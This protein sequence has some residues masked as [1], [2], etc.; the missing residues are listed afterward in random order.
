[1]TAFDS[2][3]A[4]A[5]QYHRAGQ[6]EEAFKLYRELLAA[7]PADPRVHAQLGLL[8]HQHGAHGQAIEHFEASLRANEAQPG[9]WT[10]RGEAARHLGQLDAAESCFRRALQ[11]KPDCA[12]THN[13]LGLVLAQRGRLREAEASYRQALAFAPGKASTWSNLAN[14]LRDWMRFDEAETALRKAIELDPANPATRSNLIFLLGYRSEVAPHEIYAEARQYNAPAPD[15]PLPTL[16]PLSAGRRLRIGYLSP[17]FRNHP[18]ATFIEPVLAGHDA[19]R[20]DVFCY[21][22]VARPDDVTERLRSRVAAWHSIYTLND[23]AATALIRSHQ[24][25]VLIDLAGHT[26]GNRLGVFARRAAPLQACY[27]GFFATT[28]LRTMDYWISDD[29]LHAADYQDLFVEQ[30]WRLPRCWL[31]YQ[32]PADAPAPEVS[33]DRETIVFGSFN[34]IL[35]VTPATVQLW[36][37]VLQRVP[38]SRLLLKTKSLADADTRD[39]LI[40]LF[41]Q[42]GIA[43]DRVELLPALPS[44]N[45]H[46]ASYA[47]VDIALDTFPYSGGTTTCE[48]LWMGVPLVTLAGTTMPARMS[49]SILTAAGFADRCA[50]SSEDFVEIA[51]R[52]ADEHRSRNA[53]DR[54]LRRR[55]QR[56]T[57]ANSS[58]CDGPAL[59]HALE[60]AYTRMVE[61]YLQRQ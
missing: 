37:E 61:E 52:L 51:V 7:A 5:V 23:P 54:R 24:L 36:A 44:R 33:P 55:Q 43:A 4:F 39:R 14:V 30:L 25:D 56:E 27:L 35:K 8:L 38:H 16:R 34:Q 29:V 28:G 45:E 31:A 42:R 32:A 49:A 11:Y 17:D 1:M 3:L 13:N 48:A 58:L 6:P 18:V 47:K 40:A 9:V 53:D 21:A 46:L 19:S 26:A 20:V 15:S 12:I 59:A 10:N 2:R 50:R 60:D 41:V 57:V 22:N